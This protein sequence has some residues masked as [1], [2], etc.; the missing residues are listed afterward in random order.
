M[1]TRY[2]RKH[3]LRSSLMN[4]TG[5]P[6]DRKCDSIDTDYTADE[7]EFMMAMQKYKRDHRRPHPTWCEVLAVA[8]SLGYALPNPNPEN[9]LGGL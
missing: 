2:N 7:L 4:R 8:K 1:S 9:K 3:K 6:A 5:R